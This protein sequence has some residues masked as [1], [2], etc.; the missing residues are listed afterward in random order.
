MPVYSDNLSP[1]TCINPATSLSQTNLVS[2][3]PKANW[4]EI[5]PE[6][7]EFEEMFHYQVPNYSQII[8]NLTLESQGLRVK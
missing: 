8:S 2:Q 6:N 1:T 7:M 5:D 4:P 3:N